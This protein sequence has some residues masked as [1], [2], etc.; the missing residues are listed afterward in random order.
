MPTILDK[1]LAVKAEEIAA[2]SRARDLPSLRREAEAT[3]HDAVLQPRDFTDAVKESGSIQ[4]ALWN[5]GA[6]NNNF[7]TVFT[8]EWFSKVLNNPLVESL[9]AE[10][11]QKNWFP[12]V[13][14]VPKLTPEDKEEETMRNTTVHDYF[15]RMQEQFVYGKAS[16]DQD[17]DNYVKEINDKGVTKLLEI[18]NNT[19]K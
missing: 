6:S 12:S 5:V 16:V 8:Y 14:K 4:K 7:T 9:T 10:A 17:W 2:A 1:I 13:A 11:N 18:Y 19:L 15:M 3:R